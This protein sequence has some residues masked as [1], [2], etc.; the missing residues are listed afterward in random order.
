MLNAVGRAITGG[1]VVSAS[2]VPLPE[3][4]DEDEKDDDDD[5]IDM[6]ALSTN[7][8]IEAR[9]AAVPSSIAAVLLAFAVGRGSGTRGLVFGFVYFQTTPP[10]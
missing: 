7:P 10:L 5:G 6:E 2:V 1:L 3:A 8:A 9:S 4:D